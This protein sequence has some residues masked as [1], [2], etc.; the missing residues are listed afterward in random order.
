MLLASANTFKPDLMGRVSFYVAC[1]R[2]IEHLKVFAFERQGL[3]TEM[4]AA[5][6]GVES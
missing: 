2:A 4:E 1:T 3:V 6:A 5:V